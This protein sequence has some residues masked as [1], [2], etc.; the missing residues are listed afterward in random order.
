MF[1]I[2]FIDSV[3]KKH[4][5]NYQLYEYN[6]LMEL[7]WDQGLEDWGDYKGRAW[8]GT[9][10]VEVSNLED[11][12]LP[13]RAEKDRLR[14]LSNTVANSRLACQLFLVKEVHQMSFGFIG[15]D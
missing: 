1:W 13:D 6:N 7:I 15:D 3:G 9:C 8:C 10:H 11:L 4:K 14:K 2:Y 12:L 5:L